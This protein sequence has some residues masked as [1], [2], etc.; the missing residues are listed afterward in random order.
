MTDNIWTREEKLQ[1]AEKDDLS[2]Q[3][4]TRFAK[5]FMS[6]IHVEAFFHGNLTP[7]KALELLD[8][9]ENRI[10]KDNLPIPKVALLRA[11]TLELQPSG[12]IISILISRKIYIYFFGNNN[13]LISRIF[14]ETNYFEITNDIHKSSCIFMLLQVGNDETRVNTVLDLFS[15]IVR[16]PCFD[17]LRTK[18]QV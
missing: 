10:G 8:V 12:N 9:L 4:L 17:T 5:E 14:S 3:A 18:E 15:Q 13:I 7:E 11:R 2:P 6:R 1:A 16:E